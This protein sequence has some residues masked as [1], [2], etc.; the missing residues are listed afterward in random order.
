[1]WRNWEVFPPQ[2]LV[3]S[4]YL[5]FWPPDRPYMDM[6]G[7]GMARRGILKYSERYNFSYDLTQKCLCVLIMHGMEIL[8]NDAS[9]WPED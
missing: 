2:H 4:Q 5:K 9:G 8:C 1:M 7:L 6:K 3:Y